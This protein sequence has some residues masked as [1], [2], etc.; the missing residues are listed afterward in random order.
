LPIVFYGFFPGA[1]FEDGPGITG[2][3]NSLAMALPVLLLTAAIVV[4]GIFPD[5]I[6]SLCERIVH[7]LL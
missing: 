6:V 5:A 2:E 4:L 1:G 3:G 7:G